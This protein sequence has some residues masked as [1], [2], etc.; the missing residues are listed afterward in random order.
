MPQVDPQGVTSNAAG[1]DDHIEDRVHRT[2]SLGRGLRVPYPEPSGESATR[3]GKANRR[4]DTGPE[5][6]LRSALHALGLR[7]RKDHL[8]RVGGARVR[9]DLVF[10]RAKVAVFVDGCFWHRCPEHSTTPNRNLEYWLP[11][12]EANKERDRR[13][14][15]ALAG[16]DWRV[17]RVWEHEP[18]G[19]AASRVA[20]AVTGTPTDN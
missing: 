5:V 2:V 10:T 13:V 19:E 8:L 14:D 20:G 4:S 6:R 12:L 15:A 1:A 11:K 3:V 16:E 9:P 18:V 17:V 7:F